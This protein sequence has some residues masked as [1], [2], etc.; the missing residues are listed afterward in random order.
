MFHSSLPTAEAPG[1]LKIRDDR[2]LLGTDREKTVLSPQNQ[3]YNQLGQDCVGAGCSVDLF[4]FNNSY[5]DIATIGQV[6]RL[7]GGEVFK[8]TYFQVFLNFK[9][10]LFKI[11]LNKFLHHSHKYLYHCMYI[12]TFEI[13]T[14]YFQNRYC[15]L[16]FKSKINVI[17]K[18]WEYQFVCSSKLKNIFFIFKFKFRLSMEKNKMDNNI[19]CYLYL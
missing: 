9:D 14:H 6:S 12:S 4:L 19:S 10:F 3:I 11:L 15:Y 5:I 7:T 13:I 17:I 1:K 16:G 2:K 8:Y 18:L